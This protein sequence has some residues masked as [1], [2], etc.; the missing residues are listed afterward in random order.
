MLGGMNSSIAGDILGKLEKEK[1]QQA[2]TLTQAIEADRAAIE[3]QQLANQQS[4]LQQLL[5]GSDYY[6][7]L[8]LSGLT[9][10]GNVGSSTLGTGLSGVSN[11]N[12]N[13]INLANAIN[14]AYQQN[15][16]NALSNY[17]NSWGSIL[18]PAGYSN[19]A[20]KFANAFV[21]GGGI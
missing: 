13:A 21:G 14:S 8:A 6:T 3:Q 16:N 18:S 9:G 19:N 10:V 4:A 11:L 20:S 17:N 1:T 5:G 15:Y 2:N 12:S 7:N